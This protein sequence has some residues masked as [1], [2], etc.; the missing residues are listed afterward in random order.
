VGKSCSIYQKD[1]SKFVQKRT[2]TMM[3]APIM[4][5][6]TEKS[7]VNE[8]NDGDE[9]PQDNGDDIMLNITEL[10]NTGEYDADQEIIMEGTCISFSLKKIIF[11]RKPSY[12]FDDK[13]RNYL[14]DTESLFIKYD[15]K[16]KISMKNYR[17]ILLEKQIHLHE[18]SED[19]KMFYQKAKKRTN[20]AM[21]L[22]GCELNDKYSNKSNKFLKKNPNIKNHLVIFKRGNILCSY[23]G[24]MKLSL[25]KHLKITCNQMNTTNTSSDSYISKIRFIYEI[26]H[27]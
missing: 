6:N 11:P 22:V 27:L 7:G 5:M 12:D 20:N 8:S 26:L 15:E 21:Y 24:E 18:I 25:I 9:R 3:V 19:L 17:Q 1:V 13:L 23:L 10:M 4:N 16:C 14:T 2:T